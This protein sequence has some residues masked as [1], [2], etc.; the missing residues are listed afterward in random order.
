MKPKKQRAIFNLEDLL[1]YRISSIYSQLSA[2]TARELQQF[3]LVLREWRVIAMLAR[4]EPLSASEL[5]AR[6]PMDK[7]SVSRALAS[8]LERGL[9]LVAT[10]PTDARIKVLRLT[11]AG[12]DLYQRVAPRSVARQKALLSA[13]TSAER[14]L[15]G[16]M[17][18]RI[19][20]EIVRHF[21]QASLPA[22][23]VTDAHPRSAK[24]GSR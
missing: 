21:S 9:L 6:S 10:S 1:T 24:A 8:L 16:S 23:S 2:G 17:L 15:F 7:A 19:E 13:L 12:W 22:S 5:V 4:H 3:G 11:P 18:A 14:E 20:K